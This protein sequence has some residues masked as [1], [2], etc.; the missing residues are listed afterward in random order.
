[1]FELIEN[2]GVAAT[3]AS[4]K[5]KLLGEIVPV[6]VIASSAETLDVGVAVTVILV[7]VPVPK[8]YTPFKFAAVNPLL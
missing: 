1:M 6:I 5:L 8:T 7:A 3:A 2:Y 4:A